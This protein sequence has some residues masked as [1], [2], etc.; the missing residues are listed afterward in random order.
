VAIPV[1]CMLNHRRPPA[2]QTRLVISAAMQ[3]FSPFRLN[4]LASLL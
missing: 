1:D 3:A 2:R 4:Q